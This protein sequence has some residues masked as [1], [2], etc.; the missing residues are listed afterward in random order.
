MLHLTQVKIVI[1]YTVSW[2]IYSYL[3]WLYKLTN[4]DKNPSLTISYWLKIGLV[5]RMAVQSQVNYDIVCH[6]TTEPTV[7]NISQGTPKFRGFP[8]I[9]RNCKFQNWGIPPN[10]EKWPF[11]NLVFG[12]ERVITICSNNSWTS[13]GMRIIL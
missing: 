11:F 10:L 2:F 9:W 1:M 7:T 5:Q 4:C 3:S 8:Q 12:T 6:E 13:P